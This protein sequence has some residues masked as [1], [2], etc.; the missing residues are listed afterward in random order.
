MVTEV[1]PNESDRLSVSSAGRS[2]QPQE[3]DKSGV[4]KYDT[5]FATLA[6]MLPWYSVLPVKNERSVQNPSMNWSGR[7]GQGKGIWRPHQDL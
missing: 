2:V 1:K 6:G 4:K 5:C 7:I 3:D